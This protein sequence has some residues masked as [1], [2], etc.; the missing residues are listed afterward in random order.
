MGENNKDTYLSLKRK[1]KKLCEE[2][3]ELHNQLKFVYAEVCEKNL[4]EQNW[5]ITLLLF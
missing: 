4:R 5:I 1:I 2:N 3:K